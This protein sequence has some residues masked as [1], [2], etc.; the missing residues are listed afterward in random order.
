M[1]VTL[2]KLI[3]P[4]AAVAAMLIAV[5]A[6]A[7]AQETA[8]CPDRVAAAQKEF[9]DA[10]EAARQRLLELRVEQKYIDQLLELVSDNDLT[11]EDQD[12]ARQ[13]YEESG[14]VYNV[15]LDAPADLAKLTRILHAAADLDAAR[16]AGCDVPNTREP[17]PADPSNKPSAPVDPDATSQVGEVP[18]GAV[19]TGL[20]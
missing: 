2:K 8:G 19:D 18:V 11:Q 16:K 9:D 12:R 20:A 6:V 17:E 15:G 3:F 14:F 5:P 1:D 7:Q 4:I 13:I 10:V